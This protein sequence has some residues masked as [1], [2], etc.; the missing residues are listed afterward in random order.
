MTCRAATPPSL[1]RRP[2]NSDKAPEARFPGRGSLGTALLWETQQLGWGLSMAHSK[3]AIRP[4]VGA[5][6]PLTSQTW[7]NVVQEIIIRS[8]VVVR[9]HK[10]QYLLMLW[11]TQHCPTLG[12]GT[13]RVR[14]ETG[15]AMAKL[16]SVRV[17]AM[18]NSTMW[19][20]MLTMASIP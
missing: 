13:Q 2:D 12:K 14:P 8:S 20:A 19:V 4:A 10:A 7:P 11:P 6:L 18:G 9:S 17:M 1:Q 16:S 3:R 15:T 5:E